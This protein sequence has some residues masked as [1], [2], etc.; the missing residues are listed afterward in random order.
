M[1][2]HPLTRRSRSREPSDRRR[3]IDIVSA[4][5]KDLR[6]ASAPSAPGPAPVQR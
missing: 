2:S 5:R 1:N 6:Q 4:I 3:T